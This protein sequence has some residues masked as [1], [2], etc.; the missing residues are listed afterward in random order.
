MKKGYFI[1]GERIET[2]NSIT[3]SGI[4]KKILSQVRLLK[5]FYDIELDIKEHK[6][7][8][9]YKYVLRKI[10]TRLPFTGISNC[11][12]IDEK[13][14]DAD[15]IYIRRGN[16]DAS[17]VRFL[18]NVKNLKPQIM[19]LFEIP[20]YPYIKEFRGYKT[21]PYFLKDRH[22]V[23]KLKNYIDR[24]ITFSDDKVIYGIPTIQIANGIDFSHSVERPINKRYMPNTINL[25]A[26][27][28]V[29]FWHGYE[30]LIKGL[31]NYYKFGG[32]RNIIFHLVGD[33]LNKCKYE[34]IIRDYKLDKH[35]ILYGERSGRDLDDIYDLCDVG[36]DSLACHRKGIYKLSSLKSREY[37][38]KGLPIVSSTKIDMFDDEYKYIHYVPSDETDIDIS[39]LILFYDS[40]YKEINDFEIVS[41]EIVDHAKKKCD[42]TITM[43]PIINYIGM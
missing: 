42:L 15:F 19:I 39:A 24:I 8:S 33:I 30:R 9:R 11:W 43:K 32:T 26:V 10:W 21:F 35:V 6:Q 14:R 16:I 5:E 37:S 7:L 34:S 27:A 25:I 29:R 23:R 28:Q 3:H 22:N 20:T 12:I 31:G 18:K 36:I 2:L 13:Y 1:T 38:A 17:F 40:I 41:S 4:T